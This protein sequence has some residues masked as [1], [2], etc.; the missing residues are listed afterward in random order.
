MNIVIA[1][2]SIPVVDIDAIVGV[3]IANISDIGTN[4]Y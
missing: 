3:G 2:V 4:V 1:I